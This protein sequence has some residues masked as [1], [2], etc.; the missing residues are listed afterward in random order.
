[1]QVLQYTAE[2]YSTDEIAK[3]L[4]ISTAT[5]RSHTRNI[6]EKLGAK[7]LSHAVAIWLMRDAYESRCCVSCDYI[8]ENLD[9][10]VS[11]L[12]DGADL[13]IADVDASLAFL[14]E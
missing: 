8:P 11:K 1:M 7:T 4:N 12:S 5:V 14:R 9:S 6:R 10:A 3:S 13:C 2:G